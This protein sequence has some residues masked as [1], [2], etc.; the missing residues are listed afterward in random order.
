MQPFLL[1]G[2]DGAEPALVERWMDAGA[3]PNLAALRA[4]GCYVPC[5]STVPPATFPAWTT[6][7]TGVNPGRHGIFDFTEIPPGSREL[8]FVNS[9]FRRAPALWDAVAAAGGRSGILGVPATY[10][11]EPTPGFMVS[12]FDSPVTTRPDASF[13]HPRSLYPRVRA[14]RFAD[15]QESRIG[16]GWHAMALPRLL[17]AIDRKTAIACDLLRSERPDFFMVV[18]GESDTVAHHFWLF[19]DPASPRHVPDGPAH[20][21]RDVYMRLDAAVGRLIE[22]AD[23]RCVVGVVSDH[24]FGGAGAGVVHLNN[25]LAETGWLGFQPGGRSLAKSLA[26][27]LTPPGLRGALFRRFRRQAARAE[28]QSRF[29]GI[30]WARTRA[31]SE[32]LPYFP[33]IRINLRGRDPDGQVD[34]ADYD[35]VCA[36]LCAELTAWPP[37]DRAL[38]RDEAYTGPYVDAAPDILLIPALEDGYAHS[39]LRARGGPAFRRIAPSEML[40]GKERGMNG[41]HRPTGVLFLSEPSPVGRATLC[42]V[43]P[44]IL[45]AMGVPAPPIEGTS[46]LD[47]APVASDDALPEDA[48]RAPYAPNEERIIE[49]R[50]RALGYFE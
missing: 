28:A 6:C 5:D 40:G 18:F 26:L 15:F 22:A 45:A 13:V 21:I 2:L 49:D 37:I 14:W 16:P 27:R 47:V 1:I 29:G 3:L 24:G 11:P 48:P 32:E 12:G 42:D 39:F 8:R 35:R 23:D 43:A 4:S 9:T 7:V 38:H 46:L 10:P 19:H 31:W 50:L 41:V 44:T 30:D 20:A 25:R 34:P 17:D 36:D 33:S